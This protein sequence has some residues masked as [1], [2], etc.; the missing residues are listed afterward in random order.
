[1]TTNIDVFETNLNNA[2]RAV[3]ATVNGKESCTNKVTSISANST[4]E[5]YP[6]AKCVY[7]RFYSVYTTFARRDNL[8]TTISSSSSDVQFPSA[9]CVYDLV[10][11]IETLLQG[12]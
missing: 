9:K 12:V 11:N 1:M 7:D 2:F 5:Q 6:S 3:K 4:D 8:V 10:G